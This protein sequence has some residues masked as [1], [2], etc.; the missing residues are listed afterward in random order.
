M[1]GSEE[2]NTGNPG[3]LESGGVRHRGRKC[4]AGAGFKSSRIRKASG[5]RVM[6]FLRLKLVPM[7]GNKD[8]VE[9]MECLF[10]FAEMCLA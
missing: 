4:G 1:D 8:C 5:T 9:N 7:R 3:D 6:D 10:I 2:A